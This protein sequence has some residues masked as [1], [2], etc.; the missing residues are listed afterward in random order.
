MNVLINKFHPC[1]LKS[2]YRSDLT[3]KLGI[4]RY[5][6][7]LFGAKCGEHIDQDVEGIVGSLKRAVY[8]ATEAFRLL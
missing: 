5:P 6:C 7:L 2:I 1:I 8:C 3:A 4:F